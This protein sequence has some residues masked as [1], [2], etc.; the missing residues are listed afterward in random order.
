MGLSMTMDLPRTGRSTISIRKIDLTSRKC[1]WR[2]RNFSWTR[3]MVGFYLHACPVLT[4]S[5]KTWRT[6]DP[7]WTDFYWQVISSWW[8]NRRRGEREWI[9]SKWPRVW[10]CSGSSRFSLLL[11]V[12][13]IFIRKAYCSDW[14]SKWSQEKFSSNGFVQTSFSN[15]SQYVL[16]NETWRCWPSS[17]LQTWRIFIMTFT[18]TKCENLRDMM[19]LEKQPKPNTSAAVRPS[20]L[21]FFSFAGEYCNVFFDRNEQKRATRQQLADLWVLVYSL[22]RIFECR[23]FQNTF[24]ILSM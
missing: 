8:R 6:L 1:S 20:V 7:C 21:S 3:S 5:W 22:I 24:R 11:W 23:V 12:F 10:N 15:V 16:I 2:S 19:M 13:L 9:T 14:K 4:S 18:T 17:S